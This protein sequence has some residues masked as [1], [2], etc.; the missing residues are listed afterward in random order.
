MFGGSMPISGWDVAAVL[1]KAVTY[2]ATLTA[3]GGVFFLMY[4]RALLAERER[5]RIRRSVGLLIAVAILASCGRIAALTASMSDAFAGMFDASMISLLLSGGEGRATGWRLSGLLLMAA[6]LLSARRPELACIGAVVA[7][8]SFAAVGHAYA[9]SSALPVLPVLVL[10]VH[11]VCVAFWLGALAPLLSIAGET[12]VARTAALAARF[13]TAALGVVGILVI[14]GSIVLSVLLDGVA[15][16]WTTRYGRLVSLKLGLVI[17]LLAFA[18]F[19]K[20]RW[21]PRLLAGDESAVRALRRSIKAEMLIA[22]LI[23]LVTATFTTVT[24]P[25]SEE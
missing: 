22:G 5:L 8:V 2:A 19:N 6:A 25:G 23:L 10:S 17:L 11:L 24:G 15:Q 3:A 1:L 9:A 20:L 13:G 18:A 4:C 14:T 21:T 7:V 16:L 12:G